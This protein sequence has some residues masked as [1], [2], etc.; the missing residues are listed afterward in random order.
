MANI[1]EIS[2]EELFKIAGVEPQG[3]KITL[4]NEDLFKIAGIEP[5]PTNL[6]LNTLAKKILPTFITGAEPLPGE[7]T[8]LGNLFDRPS[9]ANRE[10]IRENPALAFA[11]PLAGVL[12]AS[13]VA[14][15]EAKKAMTSGAMNPEQSEPFQGQFI[16][17]GIDSNGGPSTSVLE[18]FMKGL[19]GSVK[20]FALDMATNPAD[21]L[22][23]MLS[24]GSFASGKSSAGMIIKS[25]ELKGV[26]KPFQRAIR[27]SVSGRQTGSIKKM[28]NDIALAFDTISANKK[29]L[30]F[31]DDA[32]EIVGDTPKNLDQLSQSVQQTKKDVFKAYNKLK[33]IANEELRVIFLDDISNELLKGVD[34]VQVKDLSPRTV[35]YA[36]SLSNTLKDRGFYSVDEAQ[37]AMQILN[38]KLQAYYKNPDPNQLGENVIDSAVANHLR[39]KLDDVIESETGSMYSELKRRYG[40][41]KSIEKDVN[42]RAIVDQRKNPAGLLDYTDIFTGQQIAEGL[43]TGN[44]IQL[45][46]GAVGLTAKNILKR[47]NDA[48]RAVRKSFEKVENIKNSKVVAKS[49]IPLSITTGRL[50]EKSKEEGKPVRVI[51]NAIR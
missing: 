24:G 46:R 1:S 51:R 3:Q 25:K 28:E 11:G 38:N 29:N 40:A 20:G 33:N 26:S 44:P 34:K 7:R 50:I 5:T 21:A 6:G 30:K 42:R 49:K 31:I 9:A 4:S 17:Q 45:T 12:A 19:G 47:S 39:K 8:A 22:L 27:P 32:G 23:N 15:A 35:S 2:D 18:N 36:K 14:G 37:D 48:N 16:Q 43:L 10:A 41:L 13:G